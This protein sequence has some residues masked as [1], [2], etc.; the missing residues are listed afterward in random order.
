MR[1]SLFIP[2]LFIGAAAAQTNSSQT[3]DAL[4]AEVRQ[5]RV[6]VERAATLGPTV[7]LLLQ[8]AQIQE[9]KVAGLSRDLQSV[10]EQLAHFASQM[11]R[12]NREVED[13]DTVA[14]QEQNPLLRKQA[15][16]RARELKAQLEQTAAMEGQLRARESEVA[17]QLRLEQGKLDALEAR[18][19][20]IEKQ[21]NPPVPR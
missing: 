18:L 21:L 8:R 10:R 7:Q 20:A 12:M 13:V 2:V 19:D 16:D 4:L 6:A 5:L 17:S 3:L 9:A 14:K 15:E 1:K 11:P